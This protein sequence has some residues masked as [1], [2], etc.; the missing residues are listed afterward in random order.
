MSYKFLGL[1]F[2]SSVL[3]VVETAINT[4]VMELIAVDLHDKVILQLIQNKNQI[5]QH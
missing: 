1:S 4:P 5:M 3:N 2:A